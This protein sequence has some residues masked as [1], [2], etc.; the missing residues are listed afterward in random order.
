[1]FIWHCERETYLLKCSGKTETK[2]LKKGN[3]KDHAWEILKTRQS[4]H[5]AGVDI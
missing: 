4:S 1:M 3:V 5:L 2:S